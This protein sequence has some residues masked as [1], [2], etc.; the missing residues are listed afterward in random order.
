VTHLLVDTRHFAGDQ[1]RYFAPFDTRIGERF[2]GAR[3][4]FAALKAREAAS[5]FR[6]EARFLLDL[7]RLR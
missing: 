6:H 4:D 5:V 7:E 3:G 1:P 2:R